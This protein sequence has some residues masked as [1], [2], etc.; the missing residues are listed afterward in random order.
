M[1]KLLLFVPCEKLIVDENGNP[2]LVSL[3]QNIGL[4]IKGD[5][6][7]PEDAIAPR[8]WD[9]VTLWE[10]AE[11]EENAKVVQ[12][13]DIEYP[14]GKLFSTSS[15]IEFV[16]EKRT[17]RNKIHINGFPVGIAGRYTLKLWLESLT[18][19]VDGH[20]LVTYPISV[21]HERV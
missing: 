14:N 16:L 8:E 7:V 13:L 15:R 1:P 2:T 19:G 5:S 18:P 10:P 6:S 20:P 3:L 21:T 9:I 4:Q 17:H 11:G 12:R